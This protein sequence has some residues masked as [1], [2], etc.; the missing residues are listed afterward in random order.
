MSDSFCRKAFVIIKNDDTSINKVN[1][2]FD[3]KIN[4]KYKI[5]KLKHYKIKEKDLNKKEKENNNQ[6]LYSKKVMHEQ[7]NHFHLKKIKKN[8]CIRSSLI[9]RFR[10][11]FTTFVYYK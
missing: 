11:K 2:K 1:N 4:D 7:I 9:S 5:K 10:L 8:N 6:I 3:N